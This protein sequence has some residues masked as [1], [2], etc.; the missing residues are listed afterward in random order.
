MQVMGTVI[1][2]MLFVGIFFFFGNA[3]KK[4]DLQKEQASKMFEVNL[5]KLVA[6]RKK[7]EAIYAG[8][9]ANSEVKVADAIKNLTMPEDKRIKI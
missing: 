5:E 2:M 9:D 8:G 1:L 3:K 6:E 4:E 7:I